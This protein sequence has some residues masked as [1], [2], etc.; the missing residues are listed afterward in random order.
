ML[1]NDPL[2]GS[3]NS[4]DAR[5]DSAKTEASSH[6]AIAICRTPVSSNSE[7]P[8][9]MVSNAS[10]KPLDFFGLKFSES[11]WLEVSA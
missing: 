6:S 2:I 1:E 4:I 8:A 11:G 5:S 7:S 9:R 10:L 3:P